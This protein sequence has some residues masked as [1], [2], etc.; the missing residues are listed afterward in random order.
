M[1]L[2]SPKGLGSKPFLLKKRMGRLRKKM[3]ARA[4]GRAEKRELMEP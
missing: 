3:N 2:E 1:A 4:R